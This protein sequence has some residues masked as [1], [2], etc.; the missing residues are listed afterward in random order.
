MSNVGHTLKTAKT[1]A[2]HA[3][4]TAANGTRNARTKG[5]DAAKLAKLLKASDRGFAIAEYDVRGNFLSANENFCQN[6]GYTQEE[7]VGK[8]HRS[9]VRSTQSD[10][11][12]YRSTWS[13]L[14][15]G[16][17][18]AGAMHMSGKNNKEYWVNFVLVPVLD[19]DGRVERAIEFSN[20]ITATMTRAVDAERQLDAVGRYQ[21]VIEFD[22]TGTIINAND[23]FL[24]A[25]GYS[26]SEIVGRK[27]RIFVKPK[28]I[29]S[30][31]YKNFWRELAEGI[32]QTGEFRRIG[33]SGTEIVLEASYAPILGD[34]GK[35]YKVVKFARD[36]TKQRTE[37]DAAKALKAETSRKFTETSAKLH[38]AS[39]SLSGVASK[40]AN[41]AAQTATEA[42]N[43]ASAAEEMK[44]NVSSVA[45][46][47]EQMSM[48]TK[49]IASNAS[50]SAK[51]ASEAKGLAN[52][53]NATVQAL[54]SGAAAIGKM[55]KVIST[56]AQQTN[57]LALNAAIE[58]ARA[59]EAGKGFAVVANEVKE[60]AKQTARATEE[61]T[62][63][64][65]SIQ[66]DTKRSVESIGTIAKV[67]EQIDGYASSI[68]LSVD[69][70]AAAVRDI[71]RNASEVSAGVGNVVD[72]ISGVANA[73]HESQQNADLA[74]LASQKVQEVSSS[75]LTMAND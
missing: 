55:T 64:V 43:V 68:A 31:A 50:E 44:K 75:L 2:G 36:V 10:S 34:D 52:T 23:N 11:E 46:A 48:T 54:N 35:P 39:D 40:V 30:D 74:L 45:S 59:G 73:A 56:I 12:F 38:D 20:E 51:T 29:E 37:S 5:D 28:D 41:G 63:Q 49:E 17:A 22:L 70:Q 14:A 58:A 33:K 67:I 4:R 19:H 66:G 25:V 42:T 21:A 3:K 9:I 72:S 69:Q 13:E 24:K 1:T 60:L 71:A 18:K 16:V 26:L 47:A 8:N 15:Q 27:H 7:L 62:S 65:D 53:A 32:V 57:L 6:S 61:I